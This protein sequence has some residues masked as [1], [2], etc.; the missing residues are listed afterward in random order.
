MKMDFKDYGLPKEIKNIKINDRD[1]YLLTVFIVCCI[2]ICWMTWV[3]STPDITKRG[4]CVYY[5]AC[6][7]GL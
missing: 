3:V 6:L 5:M 1:K 7:I 2:L 4:S